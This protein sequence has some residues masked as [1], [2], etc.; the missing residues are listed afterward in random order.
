M[1]K[2][3]IFVSNKF[4]L[5]GESY[6]SLAFMYRVH[7]TTIGKIVPETCSA[8]VTALSEEYYQVIQNDD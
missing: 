8:L 3:M 2:S 5:L 6:S 4:C 7:A 1:I